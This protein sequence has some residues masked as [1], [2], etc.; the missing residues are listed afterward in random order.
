MQ[1]DNLI[2]EYKSIKSSPSL[3]LKSREM[4]LSSFNQNFPKKTWFN[5]N[6]YL[7]LVRPAAVSL[8]AVL[9]I[10]VFW[11]GLFYG[12][13]NSLPSDFLYPVKLSTEKVRMALIFSQS[14]KTVLRA[15]ILNNRLVDFKV[16][17]EKIEKGDKKFEPEL[18][19]LAKN[20][21]NELRILKKE[22]AAQVTKEEEENIIVPFPEEE[23]LAFDQEQFI[24]DQASLPIQDQ[25]EIFTVIQSPELKKLLAETKKLLAEENL[26]MA[27]VR[28]IEAEK[29]FQEPDPIIEIEQ[30]LDLELDQEN[31]EEVIEEEILDPLP[32]TES[33]IDPVGS[34]GQVYQNLEPKSEPKT[35]ENFQV[36]FPERSSNYGAGL[37]RE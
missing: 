36:D 8:L 2:K 4:L 21:T 28:L 14:K 26:S 35:T 24:Y 30:D 15:E 3:E 18:N 33:E 34:I 10:F 13:K 7:Y 27:L 12:S 23:L 32:I 37:I 25:R 1:L 17:V 31:E 11:S 5:Y 29:A 9:F 22:I 19:L 6:H 16:M 20:F